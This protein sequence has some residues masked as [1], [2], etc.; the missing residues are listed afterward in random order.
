[1][2]PI[3]KTKRLQTVDTIANAKYNWQIIYGHIDCSNMIPTHFVSVM[4][5]LGMRERILADKQSVVYMVL[6]ITCLVT[7]TQSTFQHKRRPAICGH[8]FISFCNL[9]PLI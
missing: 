1:M 7:T 2:F 9:F 5:R 4:P 8:A 3:N 6:L